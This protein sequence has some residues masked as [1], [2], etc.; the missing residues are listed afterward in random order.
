[1]RIEGLLDK[2]LVLRKILEAVSNADIS[3]RRAQELVAELYDGRMEW[4]IW[5]IWEKPNG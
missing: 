4:D 3:V 1:M 5:R 2:E